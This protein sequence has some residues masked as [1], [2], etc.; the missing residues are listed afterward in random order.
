MIQLKQ[1][2]FYISY[3]FATN[4]L[5]LICSCYHL[6]TEQKKTTELRGGG[7][8]RYRGRGRGIMRLKES[9]TERQGDGDK[10]RHTRRK[11]DTDMEADKQTD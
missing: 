5:K 4:S 1:T 10:E 8:K 11:K 6:W 2:I 9:H 3:S 7:G